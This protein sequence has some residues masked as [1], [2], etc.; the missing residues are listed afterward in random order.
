M[1]SLNIPRAALPPLSAGAVT[2]ATVRSYLTSLAPTDPAG[3]AWHQTKSL[4][5]RVIG[6]KWPEAED[7]ADFGH[8]GFVTIRGQRRPVAYT[9]GVV[10][11]SETLEQAADAEDIGARYTVAEALA[12]L[13]SVEG[14]RG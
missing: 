8:S 13:A 12:V 1:Q 10:A 4:L 14:V 5:A 9:E 11:L 2:L 7:I 6:A 3:V